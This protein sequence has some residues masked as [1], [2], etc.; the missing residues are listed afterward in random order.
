MAWINNKIWTIT[1]KFRS[2]VFNTSTPSFII[3]TVTGNWYIDLTNAIANELLE[4]KAYWWINQIWTPTPD[5]LVDIVCNN[6]A[7]KFSKNLADITT[8]NITEQ[9]YIDNSWRIQDSPL[10]FIY[11]TYISVKPN[12]DYTLS[13]NKNFR[14]A[15]LMEYDTNKNFIKRTLRDSTTWLSKSRT[16]DSNTAYILF[17]S[18]PWY[19]ETMT[20]DIVQTYNFQFEEWNEAT[21][22]RQFWQI[23]AD[24]LTETIKD[25]LNNTATAEILLKI[26]DYE[27][28]QNI[29]NW[30]ITRRIWIKILDWTENRV[31]ASWSWFRQFY[32]QSTQWIIANNVSLYSNIAPYWCTA[33]NRANYQFGCYSWW[34]GNL[35]F[36]M[37]WSAEITNIESRTQYLINQYNNKTPVIVIYPLAIEESQSVP[38]Q[39]LNIQDWTNR[40]EITQASIEWLKLQAQY[41][42]TQ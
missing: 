2:R 38:W 9:K 35:C 3:K 5:N 23:Y 30:N 19:N 8:E 27:D 12:T 10:N 40:I 42:A 39:S 33:W 34:N 7:I 32:T 25:W 6:W 1:D 31:L 17:W 24:W 13:W 21:E 16:T 41:K 28:E 11:S 15:S 26:W 22:Y 14:Y 29:L 37:I 4:L 20:L 36:Q 18:N